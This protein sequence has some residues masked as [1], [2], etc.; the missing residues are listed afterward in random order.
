MN[1]GELTEEEANLISRGERPEDMDYELFSYYRKLANKFNKTKLKGA[2]FFTSV[3]YVPV[4]D[5]SFRR[6][7]DTYRKKDE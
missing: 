1:K 5:K 2:M 4:G 6:V 3:D 7:T